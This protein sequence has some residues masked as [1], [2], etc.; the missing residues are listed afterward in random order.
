MLMMQTLNIL[1]IDGESSAL[2]DFVDRGECPMAQRKGQGRG[3]TTQSSSVPLGSRIARVYATAVISV[4]WESSRVV[5]PP[6]Y[7][8]I[9][10]HAILLLVGSYA[11]PG[12]VITGEYRLSN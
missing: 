8:W 11:F 7:S 10:I 3:S 9:C 1:E 5:M 4:N 6:C 12:R 2:P